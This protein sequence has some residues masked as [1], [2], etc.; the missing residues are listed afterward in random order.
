MTERT[1]VDVK[2]PIKEATEVVDTIDL[3]DRWDAQTPPQD[4]LKFKFVNALA[5]NKR[6]FSPIVEAFRESAKKHKGYK[7]YLEDQVEQDKELCLKDEK[8]I[9]ILGP[10]NRPIF[11]SPLARSIALEKLKEKHADAVAEVE[12]ESDKVVEFKVYTV[13]ER[14]VPQRGITPTLLSKLL[15]MIVPNPDDYVEPEDQAPG[16]KSKPVTL[17]VAKAKDPA[18]N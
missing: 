13:E 6:E 15:C 8:G 5:I 7:A 14:Y 12:S 2:M 1:F 10:N 18:A 9:A 11:P 4:P 3:F 17:P 16:P